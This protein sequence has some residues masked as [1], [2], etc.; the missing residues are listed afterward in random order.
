[1]EHSVPTPSLTRIEL[2]ERFDTRSRWALVVARSTD[3]DAVSA[4]FV[5]GSAA[6]RKGEVIAKTCGGHEVSPFPAGARP[7]HRLLKS[8]I[9][10]ARPDGQAP[11]LLLQACTP[12]YGNGSCWVSTLLYAYD[13]EADAFRT[14]F[15]GLTGSDRRQETRF[16]ESGPLLGRVIVATPTPDGPAAYFIEVYKRTTVGEYVRVLKY[17]SAPRYLDDATPSVIDLE[18]SEVLRRLVQSP[19]IDAHSALASCV[20][21]GAAR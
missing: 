7:F 11:L 16:V 9:V 10:F 13:R 18:M 1:M 4:C 8:E 2:T 21:S 19:R 17:R 3:E 12:R 14:V 20:T 15:F 6:D 5:K